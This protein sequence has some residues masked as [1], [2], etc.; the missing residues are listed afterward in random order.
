MRQDLVDHKPILN[1]VVRHYDYDPGFA[2]TRCLIQPFST[3]G[4]V[5]SENLLAF[6]TRD[7]QRVAQLLV[8]M[9]MI[10]HAMVEAH[11]MPAQSEMAQ[12]PAPKGETS[13]PNMRTNP[14]HARA[15]KLAANS[16]NL[17]G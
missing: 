8:E 13:T 9:P 7:Y 11:T 17:Y 2:L 1:T 6:F 3:M 14:A 12:T 4:L 16:R 10:P 15:Q 5:I